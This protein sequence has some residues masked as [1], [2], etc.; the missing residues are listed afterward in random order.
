MGN[1]GKEGNGGKN[2]QRLAQGRG[3]WACD[4]L[5]ALRGLLAAGAYCLAPRLPGRQ[6]TEDGPRVMGWIDARGL[7]IR[8]GMVRAVGLPCSA[9]ALYQ[10]LWFTGVSWT[11]TKTRYGA[12][13]WVNGRARRV[14]HL[15]PGARAIVEGETMRYEDFARRA[16]E[17]GV[18]SVKAA[19]LVAAV[20]GALDGERVDWGKVR[21]EAPEL[22]KTAQ[23]NMNDLIRTAG[24]RGVTVQIDGEGGTAQ[25]MN[26]MIRGAIGQ[27]V[28]IA[29]PG[30]ING[31][32][33]NKG[34]GK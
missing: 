5:L 26:A 18:V 3:A 31:E 13:L 16:K 34:G 24:A 7:F 14:I 9:R 30:K 33:I 28:V 15:S 17:Q 19:Y 29:E 11:C 27:R 21:E 8:A 12:Q 20:A 4:W 23:Q 2:L 32:A 1:T 22:F 6:H 25:D 10:E